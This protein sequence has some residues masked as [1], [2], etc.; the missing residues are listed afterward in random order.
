[1]CL[2]GLL[3][4][5]S[6]AAHLSNTA[7]PHHVSVCVLWRLRLSRGHDVVLLSRRERFS[8]CSSALHGSLPHPQPLS[9]AAVPHT[10][11]RRSMPC[12]RRLWLTHT[13]LPRTVQRSATAVV[14]CLRCR[15]GRWT[16]ASTV[17]YPLLSAIAMTLF[18]Y[19]LLPPSLSAVMDAVASLA[20]LCTRVAS[21]SLALLC[22]LSSHDPLLP[23]S[24]SLPL[25]ATSTRCSGCWRFSRHS[26]AAVATR[27]PNARVCTP[28][29]RLV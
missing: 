3:L 1:M 27:C 11:L 15:G 16:T 26:A 24:L 19:L 29:I 9:C 28:A 21:P 18:T 22:C 17:P 23:L 13:R 14:A 20:C 6:A 5:C 25:C 8:R 7:A 4:G 12:T 2:C 10:P